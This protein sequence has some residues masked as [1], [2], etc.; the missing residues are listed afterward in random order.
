[1]PVSRAGQVVIL[2][3]ACVLALAALAGTAGAA[4]ITVTIEADEVAADAECSLREAISSAN[5]GDG[6]SSGCADGDADP[7]AADTIV[8][9][10]GVYALAGAAGDDANAGGDLDVASDVTL[11]GAGAGLTIIDAAAIDRLLD[12]HDDGALNGVDV[13]VERLTLLNGNALGSGEDGDGG[14]LRMRDLNGTVVVREA[15]V[16]NSSAARHGGALSLAD[17]EL[18]TTPLQVVDS[19]LRGNTAGGSGGALYVRMPLGNASANAVRVRRSTLARNGALDAGGAIFVDAGARVDVVNSTLSGNTAVL[20]GGAIALGSMISAVHLD[21]STVA[22]NTTALAGGG[23]A[24]QTSGDVQEVFMRATILAD[25]LAAAAPRNCAKI[26]G[27]GIFEAT[28]NEDGTTEHNLESADTCGLQPQLRNDLVDR[29][30]L[31]GPLADNGGPTRTHDLGSGSP[32]LDRVPRAPADRCLSAGGTDQRGVSRP[33]APDG[34]CDVGALDRDPDPVADIDGDG[35]SDPTDNCPMMANADQAD[36]D[37]DAVGDVC[38]AV[39]DRPQQPSPPAPPPPAAPPPPPPAV[40]DPTAVEPVRI[41]SLRVTPGRFRPASRG[42]S[43]LAAGVRGRGTTVRMHVTAPAR[44][45]FTLAR[46]SGGRRVGGR[47]R[48]PTR[49]TRQRARCDLPMTG[50]FSVIVG[51]GV[52]TVQISGRLHGATLRQGR[53]W[54]RAT[55]HDAAGTAGETRRTPIRVARR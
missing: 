33:S 36:V 28:S 5:A 55:P 45:T 13:T 27:D 20:G 15:V 24:I 18:A 12:V 49:R 53:Y 14:G 16:E 17:S 22:A 35:V 3:V 9:G 50:S 37:A 47:C 26:G 8:L 29:D 10:S 6:G 39:D 32:A 40:R 38:D 7:Q 21:F 19:E 41:T 1:M 11:S 34:M 54:L 30:P 4:V 43:V 23:G 48:R 52:S 42:G 46:R 2:L 25:N 44:V 31:L 51:A